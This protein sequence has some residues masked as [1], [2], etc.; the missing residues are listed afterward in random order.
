MQFLRICRIVS[1]I[2]NLHPHRHRELYT[3]ITD[4]VA[5]AIPLWNATLSPL[6]YSYSPAPRIQMDE[7]GDGY[8]D[9]DTPALEEPDT[10]DE[11]LNTAYQAYR[12][13][14]PILQPE[15]G[16]FKSPE[17][18]ISAKCEASGRDISQR[19]GP[20]NLREDYRRLQIIVKLADIHLTPEKPRYEGGSWHVEGQ[21]NENM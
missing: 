12:D 4:I 9:T 20:L 6:Q 13:S 14:R 17:E 18:R 15:P 11:A 16:E 19:K 3:V 5:Q 8:Q 10:D 1:Y 7:D 21:L 2:N